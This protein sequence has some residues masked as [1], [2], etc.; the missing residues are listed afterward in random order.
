MLLASLP[1]VG[2][3]QLMGGSVKP[4]LRDAQ[5]RGFPLIAAALI[6]AVCVF[7]IAGGASFESSLRETVLNVTSIL[8][9]TDY[10]SADYLSWA[11]LYA[12]LIR[13]S[14]KWALPYITP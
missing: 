5:I 3:V 2:Y 12:P 14:K 4:L 6:A 7:Q 10:S 9:G 8:T 13:L 1:F 11:S